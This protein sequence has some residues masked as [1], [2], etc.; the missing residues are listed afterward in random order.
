M[1][2]VG[3]SE[4]NRGLLDMEFE[5]LYKP[6]LKLWRGSDPHFKALG[7]RVWLDGRGFACS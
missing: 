4:T 1:K 7:Q 3:L 5:H 6:E 2:F